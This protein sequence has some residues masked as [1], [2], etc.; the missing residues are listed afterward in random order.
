MLSIERHSYLLLNLSRVT[1]QN[2]ECNTLNILSNDGGGTVSPKSGKR[3]K[4]V[5]HCLKLRPIFELAYK[6]IH[7]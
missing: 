3:K 6:V 4:I 5:L 7:K 2:M 1:F